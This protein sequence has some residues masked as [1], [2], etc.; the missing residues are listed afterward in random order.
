M[1][2]TDFLEVATGENPLFTE[3]FIVILQGESNKWLP[4][5]SSGKINPKSRY[6]A[7]DSIGQRYFNKLDY[8]YFWI[9]DRALGIEKDASLWKNRLWSFKI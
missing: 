2:K 7:E 5:H 3:G 4:P 9:S 8:R 6:G 1:M